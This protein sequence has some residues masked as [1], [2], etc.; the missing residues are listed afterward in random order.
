M[1]WK[2]MLHASLLRAIRTLM[3]AAYAM[4]DRWQDIGDWL[5]AKHARLIGQDPDR[6]DG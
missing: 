6:L 5:A 1:K 2:R 4:G 3:R